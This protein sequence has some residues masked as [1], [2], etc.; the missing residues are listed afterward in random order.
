MN[1]PDLELNLTGVCELIETLRGPEG[2]PW[3]IEQTP[4]SLTKHLIEECYELVEAI[5]NNDLENIE[6]EIGD[7]LLNL[8]YQIVFLKEKNYSNEKALIKKLFFKIHTRHPHVFADLKLNDSAAVE[9]NWQKIKNKA[10]KNN[11]DNIPKHLPS[12]ILAQKVQKKYSKLNNESSTIDSLSN[13]RN[14]MNNQKMLNSDMVGEILFELS[15][16]ARLNKIDSEKS[17]KKFIN[18][19][20]DQTNEK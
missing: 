16:Y 6:E 14:I 7:L 15:N 8:S 17:L 3:D 13:M 4:N 9:K 10:N 1:F 2:C 19:Y 12:L 11:T 20:M 5:E 18:D